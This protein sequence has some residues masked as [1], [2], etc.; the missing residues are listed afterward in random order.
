MEH[1][2]HEAYDKRPQKE[3][4][5]PLNGNGGTHDVKHIDKKSVHD[6]GKE[7]ES[8]H[9]ERSKKEFEYGTEEKV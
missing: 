1:N 8:E 6:D 3:R 5:V 2:V 9:H 4:Y 7:S